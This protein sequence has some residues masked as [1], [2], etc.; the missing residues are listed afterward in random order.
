MPTNPG[1]V[2]YVLEQL[3]ALGQ[4]S[5]RRMFGGVGLYQGGL[6]FGLLF[7][8][9]LYFKVGDSNRADYESRGMGRFRPYRDRPELSMTYY[10]V[11]ADVLEDAEELIGWAR[12]SVEV[13][14]A[15][16]KSAPSSKRETR[17]TPRAGRRGRAK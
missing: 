9:T 15:C 3:S 13:A 6:F 11:P 12:R 10:E 14:L 7:N 8:D 17:S 5:A 4:V 1:Y 16:A 2:S